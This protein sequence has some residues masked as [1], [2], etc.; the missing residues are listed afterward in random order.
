M[1]QTVTL[2]E[3]NIKEIGPDTKLIICHLEQVRD[4][5]NLLIM[6]AEAPKH[7][8]WKFV[9]FTALPFTTVMQH[10]VT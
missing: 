6:V 8:A 10:Q 7:C 2:K 9:V 5:E 4:V 3:F 1:T